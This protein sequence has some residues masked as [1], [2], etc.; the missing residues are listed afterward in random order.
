MRIGLATGRAVG[1]SE[2]CLLRPILPLVLWLLATSCHPAA[3]TCLTFTPRAAPSDA[4]F[5]SAE[6]DSAGH[7]AAAL[8][9]RLAERAGLRPLDAREEPM[10]VL[11][12]ECL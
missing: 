1:S 5:A 4:L 11:W 3:F 9:G 8:V 7:D 6:L 10:P 2:D 12:E